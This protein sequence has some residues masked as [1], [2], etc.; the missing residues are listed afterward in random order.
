MN[1]QT[2]FE[3]AL[4]APD[5]ASALRTL[6]LDVAKQGHSKAAIYDALEAV[7]LSLRTTAGHKVAEELVLDVMDALTGSCH[8]DARL[9]VEEAR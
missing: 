5:P 8:P 4:S 3:Q 2:H 6:I 9:L 1:L 7:V